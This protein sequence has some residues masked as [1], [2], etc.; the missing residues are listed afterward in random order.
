MSLRMTP[1]AALST[2]YPVR[3]AAAGL[4]RCLATLVLALV[5]IAVWPGT[6]DP[7]EAAVSGWKI[8][9]VQGTVFLVG[10][11]D[12]PVAAKA[13]D[14]M[15]RGMTLVTLAGSKALIS[16]FD[17]TI[18]LD[19]NTRIALSSRYHRPMTFTYLM[20]AGKVTADVKT[21]PWRRVAIFTPTMYLDLKT[22]NAEITV[23]RK[24][25]S[26]N[27]GKGS[28]TAVGLPGGSELTMGEGHVLAYPGKEAGGFDVSSNSGQGPLQAACSACHAPRN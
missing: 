17:T 10:S 23:A 3:A 28:L 18:L 25:T 7:A 26:V 13:G 4:S 5:L 14:P 22:A 19:P 27:I 6:P 20:Q 24:G 12:K 9:R 21:G 2:R 1:P 11:D 15:P 16:G 8:R